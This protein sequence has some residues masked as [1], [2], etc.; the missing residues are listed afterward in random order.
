MLNCISTKKVYVKNHTTN[1]KA[2]INRKR[3]WYVYDIAIY[4]QCQIKWVEYLNEVFYVRHK[5]NS[6]NVNYILTFKSVNAR[7]E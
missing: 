5:S 1:S 6:I 7:G 3:R 4:V 2:K